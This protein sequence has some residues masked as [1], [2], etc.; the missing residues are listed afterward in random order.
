MRL[1]AEVQK[2]VFTPDSQYLLVVTG[3]QTTRVLMFQ[4]HSGTFVPVAEN[5]SAANSRPAGAQKNKISQPA[6]RSKKKFY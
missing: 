3:S 6:Q 2:M 4:I 1:D 5:N